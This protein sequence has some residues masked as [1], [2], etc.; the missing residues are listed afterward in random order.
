MPL[1]GLANV[2]VCV[3]PMVRTMHLIRDLTFGNGLAQ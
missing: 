3:T 1:E 2:K